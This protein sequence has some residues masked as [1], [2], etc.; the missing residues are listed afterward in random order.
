MRK[1]LALAL[2]LTTATIFA[3]GTITGTVM[4][5][6]MK[7]PLPGATVMVVGTNNGTTTDFDGNF[8]LNVKSASGTVDISYVGFEKKSVQFSLA[9]GETKSLGS[10]VLIADA[11]A[12]DEIIVTSFSLAI[13]RKTPVAVSTCL[14]YTSDAADDLLCVDL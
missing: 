2:F 3:Q 11:N 8:T 1:L 9:N 7:V 5:S 4:D 10:I 14:L 13:D 12:L 6:D